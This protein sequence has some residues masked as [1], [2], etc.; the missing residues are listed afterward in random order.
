MISN[1]HIRHDWQTFVDWPQTTVKSLC[2]VKTQPR[3]A[4]IPGITEQPPFVEKKEGWCSQCCYKAYRQMLDIPERLDTDSS[5]VKLYNRAARTIQPV[6]A[7]RLYKHNVPLKEIVFVG[8]IRQSN[9]D[10]HKIS[11]QTNGVCYLCGQSGGDV[12]DHILPLARGGSGELYNLAIVHSH[13]NSLKSDCSLKN[14]PPL[15]PNLTWPSD[16]VRYNFP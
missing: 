4:G 16:F 2:N 10:S 14:L 1:R 8:R 12:T 9:K 3:L 5:V 13:C 6:V 15:F 11:E 7:R